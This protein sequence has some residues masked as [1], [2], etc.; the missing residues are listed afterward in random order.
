M[1]A[2]NLVEEFHLSKAEL[3]PLLTST[4]RVPRARSC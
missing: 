3:P 1:S 4:L 2:K